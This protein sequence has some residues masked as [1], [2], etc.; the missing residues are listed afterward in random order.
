MKT[1]AF[2]AGAALA[3]TGVVSAVGISASPVAAGCGA[4]IA[5]HNL[6]ASSVTIEWA[7]SDARTSTVVFG[8][9]IAGKWASLGTGTTVVAAGDTVNHAVV[10]N[11]S[12]N[13]DRQY[14]LEVNQNG[15]S[16]FTYFPSQTTWTRDTTPHIHP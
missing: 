13:I 1:R 3:V 5:V 16:W 8:Q 9:R 15:G 4:T 7:D 14:R 6:T 12:C 10:L 11:L 2:I